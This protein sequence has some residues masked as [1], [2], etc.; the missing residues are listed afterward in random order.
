[1]AKAT[2]CVFSD[3]LSADQ[4]LLLASNSYYYHYDTVINVVSVCL[5]TV[6]LNVHSDVVVGPAKD[7]GTAPCAYPDSA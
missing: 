6:V 3:A 2:S 5:V 7:F 1:M 4:I